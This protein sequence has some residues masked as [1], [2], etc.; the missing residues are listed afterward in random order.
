MFTVA[1][2]F[3]QFKLYVEIEKVD[4]KTEKQAN[5]VEIARDAVHTGDFTTAIK[6]AIQYYEYSRAGYNPRVNT[7]MLHALEQ[8]VTSLVK[9]AKEV[10]HLDDKLVFGLQA[11]TDIERYKKWL[12]PYGRE[13]AVYHLQMIAGEIID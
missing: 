11:F 13:D 9:Q 2:A 1:K 6:F 8:H 10:R 12:M 4:R 5:I 7:I 3:A